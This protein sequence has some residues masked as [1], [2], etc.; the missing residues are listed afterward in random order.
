MKQDNIECTVYEGEDHRKHCELVIALN[1]RY[2]EFIERYERDREITNE[3]RDEMIKS[4]NELKDKF[5]EW[6][7][8]YRIGIFVVGA[9]TMSIIGTIGAI[10]VKYILNHFKL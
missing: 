10:I 2:N 1:T 9:L 8:P 3:F 5:K 6:K 7:V 4:M